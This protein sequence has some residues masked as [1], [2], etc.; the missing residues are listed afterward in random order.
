[1]KAAAWRPWEERN[2]GGP[3]RGGARLATKESLGERTRRAGWGG[4]GRDRGGP[5][6]E[7]AAMWAGQLDSERVC[8]VADG[9]AVMLAGLL[10]GG[11]AG[12]AAAAGGTVA[13]LLRSGRCFCAVCWAAVMRVGLLRCVRAGQLRCG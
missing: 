4:G 11:R 1:M 7:G 3:G 6:G 2:Q 8:C 13:R 12:R 10:C 9:A 5:G